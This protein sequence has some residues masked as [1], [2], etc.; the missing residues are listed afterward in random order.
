MKRRELLKT[1]AY[2]TLSGIAAGQMPF[3]FADNKASTL[4]TVWGAPV[5][6]AVLLGVAARQGQLYKTHPYKVKVW[7]TPDQLRAAVANG[8][9]PVTMV[10][11]YVAANFS[12]RGKDVV[13]AN[14]MTFGLLQ[15]VAHDNKLD[16][17]EDLVGKSIVMPFKNDM[18]D[19]VLQILCKNAG[20]DFAA[21]K[22][23]YV[24]TP[25]EAMA[26]FLKQRVELAF[27]PEPMTTGAIFKG[28][29]TGQKVVRALD[30]QKEWGR[31][32]KTKPRIPQAG[33]QIDRNFYQ[34]NKPVINQL[35][36]DISAA[37]VW[38]DNNPQSAAEIGTNYLPLPKP[39][40]AAALPN[41]YLTGTRT[42]D[43][44]DE[45]L[46]FFEQMYQ[47]NPKIVGGK[48]PSKAL[49]NL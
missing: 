11:S 48:M 29:M 49:F 14:I 19:L 16:S 36:D 8:T 9:M 1:A 22:V 27:L 31:V 20:V 35:L 39:I 45:I 13:L 25:P 28:K 30:F 43:I 42:A 40:L 41:A 32:M 26:L 7:K 23:Q 38:I 44:A 6:P 5:A 46:F 3:A 33:M 47:L 15:M 21:L 34:A 37:A 12:N 10:P 4:S 24:T 17:I 2:T 18:P